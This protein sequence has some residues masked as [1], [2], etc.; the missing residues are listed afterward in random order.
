MKKPVLK[1]A[2]L[3]TA[4]ASLF[5]ISY[6]CSKQKLTSAEQAITSENTKSVNA[7]PQGVNPVT[8]K[9]SPW[10][11]TTGAP[12]NV[13][14]GNKWIE[15]FNAANRNA[16]KSYIIQ[17][18]DLQTILSNSSCVGICLYF[19][20]DDTQTAHILPI[21]VN[22]NGRLMKTSSINT[23]KGLVDWDTAQRWIAND[24]GAID[25]RFF[26]RNT[27]TRLLSDKACLGIRAIYALDDQGKPQL[28]LGNAAVNYNSLSVGQMNY[29]DASRPCPPYCPL[30]ADEAQN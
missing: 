17:S 28:L 11:T 29:E 2:L 24:P 14:T 13:Q 26:G 10:K 4:T 19:A 1:T 20:I 12:V 8:P 18:K 30:T 23:Q 27:F 5:F 6:S 25:A 15:N 21:G 3:L 16:G 22:T 9:E 7:A